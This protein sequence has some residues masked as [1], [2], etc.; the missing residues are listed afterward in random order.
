MAESPISSNR[1][2]NV[3][4]VA[5]RVRLFPAI[6][7]TTARRNMNTGK[8]HRGNMRD[9]KGTVFSR[10]LKK[11]GHT[12][13]TLKLQADFL[14]WLDNHNMVIQSPLAADTL[15]IPDPKNPGNKKRMNKILLQIPVRELHNDLV[16]RDPLIGLPGV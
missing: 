15:L 8:V 16:D 3:P 6:P 9:K 5:A 11:L 1:T 2:G 13:V 4:S 7:K 10:V 14:L 12:K